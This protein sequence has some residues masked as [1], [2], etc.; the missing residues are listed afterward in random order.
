MSLTKPSRKY[1]WVPSAE[2]KLKIGN[3]TEGRLFTLSYEAILFDVSDTL[4]EYRPNYAQIYGERL[5]GLGY[6]VCEK[7]SDEISRA[8]NYAIGEQT[9]KEEEGDSHIS[10][11]QLMELLDRAALSCVTVNDCNVEDHIKVLV[12]IPI[13][14]QE[15]LVI[16]GVI[17]VLGTLRER[18]RLAIV[19]NHYTWLMDYLHECGLSCFFESIV[20]SETVGVSKPNIRIMEI[21]MERLGVKA[22]RCLYVG[23]QPND[24][25]CSKLAGMDSVW[26]TPRDIVLPTSISY[27]PD[28]RITHISELL[29]I[30]LETKIIDKR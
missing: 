4:I 7:K 20:I 30:L 12:G 15:M 6:E 27:Q 17:E 14:K 13:P 18:Y 11:A 24:V 2:Y 19:S 29:N 9:K 5:R 26:I 1:E 25:L 16:P 8:I 28:Y 3:I 23:D 22:N 10:E 21:A